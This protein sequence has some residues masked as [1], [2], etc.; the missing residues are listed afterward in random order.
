MT[1][2]SRP[3]YRAH[4]HT[5]TTATRTRLRRT[6]GH[7]ADTALRPRFLLIRLLPDAGWRLVAAVVAVNLLLGLLPIVF[8]VATSVV[9]GMVPG[10]V[11]GGVS[12]PAWDELVR[13]FL[14]ATGAFI[15]QQALAPVQAALNVRLKRTIDGRNLDRILAITLGSVSIAPMEDPGTLDAVENATNPYQRDFSTPGEAAG[16]FLALIARYL[17]VVGFAVIVGALLTWWA[18]LAVFAATMVF[19][20]GQRGGLR[21]Y[22]QVWTDIVPVRRRAQYLRDT[23]MGA[24]AAKESRIFDLSGWLT[25]RYGESY[26]RMYAAVARRRRKVYLGPY[27]LYAAV[28]LALAGVVLVQAARTGVSG[29][30]SLTEL[31]LV[32]QSATAALLLGV[33]YI[34]SDVPTQYGMLAAAAK[35]RLERRVAEPADDATQP[36]DRERARASSA[37]T[38]AVTALP[39]E[40][41]HLASLKFAYPGSDRLVLDGLEVELPAGRSTA[42]VGVNGAGK[43]TLVKLLTRLYEPTSGR[44]LADGIDISTLDPVAWR[45]QVSVIF[46]DFVRYEL[47]AADN[48]AFGAAHVPRDDEAVREAARSAGIL[49]AFDRLPE[50]LDTKLSRAYP[51]GIDLSGGQW[52]RTAIARS[53]YALNAGARVLVLDEPTAALDVRAEV[54]FFDQFV[55]LTRGVTSLLISHRFSSVRRADR[56]VVI[57]GG[58]VVELGTHSELM[59]ADGHYARL[60]RLQAERFA[61]GL[62]AE[63]DQAATAEARAGGTER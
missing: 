49:E 61:A 21:R 38:D 23:A 11:A 48:I 6:F 1:G 34:E 44:I 3:V 58:R 14:V 4:V 39:R 20:F 46:Q 7:W 26:S 47:S 13:V 9:V 31:A 15:G 27:V 18:G 24:G 62:D 35:V 16:G 25:D 57:D 12:S 5:G 10:A 50:G 40:R 43:T 36:T 17:R 55:E 2:V 32:L 59:D 29:D 51:G 19:R 56:I 41:M 37:T 30:L 60:F 54:A 52:Q 33:H 63:D 53:L 22:S 42:V 28:G 8:V 45:R